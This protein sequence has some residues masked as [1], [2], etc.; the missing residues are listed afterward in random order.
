MAGL[1]DDLVKPRL[2]A[3]KVNISSADERIAPAPARVGISQF[4]VSPLESCPMANLFIKSGVNFT[5]V[6]FKFRILQAVLKS[7]TNQEMY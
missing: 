4:E 7:L 2:A 3:R 5:K 1:R 6:L